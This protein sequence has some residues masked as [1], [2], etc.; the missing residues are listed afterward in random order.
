MFTKRIV[1]HM[2]DRRHDIDIHITQNHL[3]G[4]GLYFGYNFQRHVENN[5]LLMSWYYE[6]YNI[7]F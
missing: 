6:V 5:R 7:Q 4:L 3:V 1:L 2:A